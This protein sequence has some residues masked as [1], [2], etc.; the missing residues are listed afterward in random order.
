VRDAVRLAR[1]FA[2]V[3]NPGVEGATLPDKPLA[4]HQEFMIAD[5]ERLLP[6]AAIALSIYSL[7]PQ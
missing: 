6:V 1:G 7:A 4:A 3:A 5:A 2:D